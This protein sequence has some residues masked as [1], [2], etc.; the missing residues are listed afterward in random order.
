MNKIGKRLTILLAL[1]GLTANAADTLIVYNMPHKILVDYAL[2][3]AID[4]EESYKSQLI[5]AADLKEVIP[6]DIHYKVIND[7]SY[8]SPI[9]RELESLME[10]YKSGYKVKNVEVPQALL[11][12]SQS[13]NTNRVIFLQTSG[14]VKEKREAI[15]VIA[16][17]AIGGVVLAT[18]KK[19]NI[20]VQTL[21]LD[22]RSNRFVY[23]E[24]AGEYASFF[25]PLPTLK[26]LK[27]SLEDYFTKGMNILWP[28]KR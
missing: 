26:V 14:I 27:S 22:L 5:L 24:L 23:Y 15:Q 1:L 28:K 16:E 7:T 9:N 19:P 17:Y 2:K 10:R 11:S 20:T 25:K 21:V 8:F 4:V 6:Q 13:L 12:W 3:Q 18:R